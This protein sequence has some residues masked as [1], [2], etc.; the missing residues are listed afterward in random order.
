MQ[1]THYRTLS[2][3]AAGLATLAI[4]ASPALAGSSGCTGG[5]CQDEDSPAPV[6]PVAPTPAPPVPLQAPAP[7]PETSGGG[8]GGSQE[9]S[10]STPTR[11]VSHTTRSSRRHT[12]VRARRVAHTVTVAQRTVP[13]GAVSAG[14]GGMAPQGPESLLLGLAGGGLVLL[15]AGG[16]LVASARRG[17][18]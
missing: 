5:D 10:S 4:G 13:R 6:V 14:A 7:A 8:G 17:V 12:V 11:H 3:L 2:M 9:H 18:S 15:A 16:G 1:R